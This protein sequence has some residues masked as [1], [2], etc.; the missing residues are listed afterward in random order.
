MPAGRRKW[1]WAVAALLGLELL[2]GA[3]V[4]LW[5]YVYIGAV[6]VRYPEGGAAYLEKP[7]GRDELASQGTHRLR[8]GRYTLTYERSGE[9]LYRQEIVVGIGEHKGI[10]IPQGTAALRAGRPIN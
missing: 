5:E 4:L 1:W 7:D 6:T 2:A 3:G 10:D 9:Q 8:P